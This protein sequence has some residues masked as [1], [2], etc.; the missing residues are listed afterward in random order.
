MTHTLEAKS[1]PITAVE[2]FKAKLAYEMTPWSLKGLLIDKKA[3][4]LCVL[5]VRSPEAFAEGHI[6]TAINIPLADLAGKLAALPKDKT[7]V[8]YCS[9][10]TCALAPKAALV[11]AEKGFKV[12]E[13]FGGIATWTEFGFPIEKTA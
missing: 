7:L 11:L 4:D 5:D 1:L 12:M 3:T 9:N 13:L 6:P 10:L 2:Y 8:T